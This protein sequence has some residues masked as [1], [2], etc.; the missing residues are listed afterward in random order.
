MLKNQDN[1]FLN[2]LCLKRI[3][4]QKPEYM[5]FDYISIKEYINTKILEHVKFQAEETVFPIPS[6]ENFNIVHNKY[7]PTISN[8]TLDK[9]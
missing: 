3:R 9:K 7:M 4:L 1:N 2:L 8:K 6:K 5:I